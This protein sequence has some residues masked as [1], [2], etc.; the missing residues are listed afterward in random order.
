MTAKVAAGV[1][2]LFT[3]VMAVGLLSELS[4]P[5]PHMLFMAV[6]LG[7]VT[8]WLGYR[9][10]RRPSRTI[11][12]IAGCVAAFFVLIMV[13]AILQGSLTPFPQGF[14][15]IALSAAGGILPLRI[16]E[17]RAHSRT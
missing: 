15:V 12:I 11:A 4:D 5:R 13:M 14:V 17:A 16:P 1:W 9:L 2:F 10:L 8:A 7:T 6:T 3:L